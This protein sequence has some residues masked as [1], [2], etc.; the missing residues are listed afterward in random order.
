MTCSS[1]GSFIEWSD[2]YFES[3]W[4]KNEEAFAILHSAEELIELLLELFDREGF[5][6]H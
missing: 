5:D 4:V 2:S 3:V 6:F 1:K